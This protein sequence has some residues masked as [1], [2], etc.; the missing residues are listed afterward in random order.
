MGILTPDIL[1]QF[2]QKM[3]YQHI[4][5]RLASKTTVDMSNEH[6]I[7]TLKKENP[8]WTHILTTWTRYPTHNCF[9]HNPLTTIKQEVLLLQTKSEIK[10]AQPEKTGLKMF[11]GVK[12]I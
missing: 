6:S 12:Y 5:C 9:I 1:V 3:D 8:T 4:G 10:W 7:N 2:L 11:E